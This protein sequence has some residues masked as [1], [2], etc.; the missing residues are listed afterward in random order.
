MSSQNPLPSCSLLPTSAESCLFCFNCSF[1][2]AEEM[3]WPVPMKAI[4]AQNL[5]T[6]PGGVAKAGY[7]HKK[8]G[9]Q[10]QMLKC[11]FLNHGTLK[12]RTEAY[13]SRA[14]VGLLGFLILLWQLA[15]LMKLMTISLA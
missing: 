9:T 1:M 10:L 12:G 6:M 3:H 13:F 2:A 14:L 15:H 5:L 7:L 4:G 8:G 11:E